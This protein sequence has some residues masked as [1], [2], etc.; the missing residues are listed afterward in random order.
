MFAALIDQSDFF[1]DKV[2]IA[3]ML[4]PVTR[5]KNLKA[6]AIQNIKGNQ[7][8]LSAVESIYGSEVQGA[9]LVE[10]QLTASLFE[11]TNV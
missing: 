9:P 2:N 4:A 10:S 11:I 6:K 3:I 7:T 8:I 1:K 5:V